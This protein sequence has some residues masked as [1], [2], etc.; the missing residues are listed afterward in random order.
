MAKPA[1]RRFPVGA[2]SSRP[3]RRAPSAQITPAVAIAAPM[4]PKAPLTLPEPGGLWS[5]ASILFSF[6]MP[7]LGLLLGLLYAG[8][9]ER[10]ARNFG[11]WC[12]AVAVFGTIVSAVTGAVRT[13]MG[14]G[15]WFVQ[16]Y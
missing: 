2:G 13:A 12:I 14:S 11:R 6:F 7:E 5:I 15:E 8:Q 16:P 10:S 1:S 3:A 4:L 9:S